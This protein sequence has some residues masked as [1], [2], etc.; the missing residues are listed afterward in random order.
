MNKQQA[1]LAAI[2]QLAVVFT[3]AMGA[4]VPDVA[5]GTAAAS[6]IVELT[7]HAQPSGVALGSSQNAVGIQT[8][9]PGSVIAK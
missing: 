1:V 7:P 9:A 6:A 2:Q 3:Q 5:L 8:A 4:D